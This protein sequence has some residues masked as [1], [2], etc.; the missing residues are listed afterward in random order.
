[1]QQAMDSYLDHE[2][3]SVLRNRSSPGSSYTHT[4]DSPQAV[5]RIMQDAERLSQSM[6][7]KSKYYSRGLS[8]DLD[9]SPA[10]IRVTVNDL[11]LRMSTVSTTIS[12]ILKEIENLAKELLEFQTWR[13]AKEP[14]DE[15][16][17]RLLQSLSK[18]VA[19]QQG[20][21]DTLSAS[22]RNIEARLQTMVSHS[23]LRGVIEV[24]HALKREMR[25]F[26][27]HDDIVP[28]EKSLEQC[29]NQDDFAEAMASLKSVIMKDLYDRVDDSVGKSFDTQA[30]D[31]KTALRLEIRKL[32]GRLEDSVQDQITSKVRSPHRENSNAMQDL[33]DDFADLQ[34]EMRTMR[35][36]M[37]AQDE[38]I[39]GLLSKC[40]LLAE[41]NRRLRNLRVRLVE[42][43]AELKNVQSALVDQEDKVFRLTSDVQAILRT[44]PSIVKAPSPPPPTAAF[45]K[46]PNSPND[47]RQ[48][49]P[50]LEH[51]T[52]TRHQRSGVGIVV[53]QLT[54]QS[55]SG[56]PDYHGDHRKTHT[57][58]SRTFSP[59]SS[60]A[61][62]RRLGQPT[63]S[64]SHQPARATASRAPTRVPSHNSVQSRGSTR[65]PASWS[66]APA[67]GSLT[68]AAPRP[69]TAGTPAPGPTRSSWGPETAQR[70]SISQFE[71]STDSE[72][73]DM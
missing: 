40:D 26:V 35:K 48:Q 68:S 42:E 1:M 7:S 67:G 54:A 4:D 58:P 52:A 20:A 9:R 61:A 17:D 16:N 38:V 21:K 27:L 44:R 29:I 30:A 45:R 55:A 59:P 8:G 22:I 13:S 50:R 34:S 57:S 14:S 41:D 70:F 73:T 56:M 3:D 66:P 49:P 62:P 24:Q 19:E 53:P 12:K 60:S 43:S 65:S 37:E 64:R 69:R 63:N 51:N 32:E 23:D 39:D 11:E 71:S 10:A 28:I 72:T 46:N 18:K 47:N 15:D 2:I 5:Q 25:D 6:K 31:L 33:R 36:R